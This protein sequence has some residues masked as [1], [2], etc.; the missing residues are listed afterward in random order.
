MRTYGG[1]G[2]EEE[3]PQILKKDMKSLASGE[4]AEGGE[5][6]NLQQRVIQSGLD[7]LAGS[8]AES[9]VLLFKGMAVF[10]EDQVVPVGILSV[11]WVSLDPQ[12]HKPL[13]GMKV[14]Q[15][16]SQLLSR[17]IL[18]G[19][20]SAGVSMHDVSKNKRKRKIILDVF[21]RIADRSRFHAEQ[22]VAVGAAASSGCVCAGCCRQRGREV[23]QY[24]RSVQP[25]VACFSRARCCEWRS[26]YAE[27]VF[28]VF[29]AQGCGTSGSGAARFCCSGSISVGRVAEF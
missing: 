19:S 1:S 9:I 29:V 28:G 18:L 11:L 27:V 7:S 25:R 22:L 10:A 24:C 13:S 15:W 21:M 23:K 3:I 20:A 8:E 17:S 4:G 16:V 5:S 26:S 12:E 6:L 2:W 14:R